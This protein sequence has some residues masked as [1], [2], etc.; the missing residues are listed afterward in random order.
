[1][2]FFTYVGQYFGIMFRWFTYEFTILDF[3]FTLFQIGLFLFILSMIWGFLGWYASGEI[4]DEFRY[5]RNKRYEV[6]GK[7]PEFWVHK[8]GTFRDAE[9]NALKKK[10]DNK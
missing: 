2:Q 10:Y 7:N 6:R 3:K 4:N 9:I 1:M 5:M 8:Q